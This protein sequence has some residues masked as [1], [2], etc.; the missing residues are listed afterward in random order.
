MLNILQMLMI[1]LINSLCW[2]D[3][4]FLQIRL[5]L[6]IEP[7][8]TNSPLDFNS[9][10]ISILKHNTNTQNNIYIFLSKKQYP[11][12]PAKLREMDLKHA[13]ILLGQVKLLFRN[14][15]SELRLV[16][17]FRYGLIFQYG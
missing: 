6:V 11:Y 15:L 16:L 4:Q 1:Y 17:L 2:L 13:S 9:N 8:R 14:L 12:M 7:T 3:K 5:K 10:D